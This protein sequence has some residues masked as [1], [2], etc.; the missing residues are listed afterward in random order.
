[1]L[2]WHKGQ[3]PDIGSAVTVQTAGNAGKVSQKVVV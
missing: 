1:V 3:R 2:W